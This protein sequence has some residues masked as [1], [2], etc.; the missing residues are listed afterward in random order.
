MEYNQTELLIC[1]AS[2]QME[3]RTSA[4]I[5]TGIPMLAAALAQKTHA[6]NLMPVFEFGGT[7]A[8]LEELPLGVGGSRTFYRALAASSICDVME[9]AQRGLIMYGFVGGAQID[10]Y[11]NLN[12]TVIGDHAKPK[13]RFPGSGGANDIGSLV[14]RTI[15]I[16]KHGVTRFVEQVDF[17]TTPGYLTGPRA[18]EAAG[19]PPGTGPYRVVS[20][21]A[22]MGFHEKTKRMTLLALNPGVTLE[23]VEDNTGFELVIPE[24]V[25]ENPPP[26]DEELHILRKE[27]D[28]TGLYI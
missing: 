12:S 28:P 23:Q 18:R 22:L 19:L 3:D 11:G 6:P 1:I 27:I 14:W 13:V 21:L 17:I 2:R 8:K 7:G 20:D 10:P 4:F 9:A 25:D 16:M 24:K 5:G 15:A 26:T